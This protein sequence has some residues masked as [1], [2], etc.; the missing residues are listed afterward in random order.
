MIGASAAAAVALVG[1]KISQAAAAVAAWAG[2]HAAAIEIGVA[3]T[4]VAIATA[5]TIK[6][7]DHQIKTDREMSNAFASE[8]AAYY[9]TNDAYKHPFGM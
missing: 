4:D 3:L 6:T 7:V 5:G 9:A 1:Y 2:A 8:A